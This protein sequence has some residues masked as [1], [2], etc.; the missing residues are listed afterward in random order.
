MISV[1]RV[2]ADNLRSNGACLAIP[3]G[4]ML[5]A[6]CASTCSICAAAQSCSVNV[7][8]CAVSG[9]MKCEMGNLGPRP[10]PN[11]KLRRSDASVHVEWRPAHRV[12]TLDIL[13]GRSGQDPRTVEERETYLAPV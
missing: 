7:V 3:A 11:G 4:A 8:I 10:E 12:Q 2:A 13:A 6:C 9:G 1:H 5:S